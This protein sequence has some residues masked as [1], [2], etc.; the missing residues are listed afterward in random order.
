MEDNK[1]YK[2]TVS[3]YIRSYRLVAYMMFGDLFYGIIERVRN[4][5]IDRKCRIDGH[6]PIDYGPSGNHWRYLCDRCLIMTPELSEWKIDDAWIIR[7]LDEINQAW[8]KSE[9]RRRAAG[10]S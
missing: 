1:Q 7:T 9:E 8:V 6:Q 5:F 3:A 2:L 4:Y 10:I